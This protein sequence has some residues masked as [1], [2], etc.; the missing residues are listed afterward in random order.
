LDEK[1]SQRNRQEA[2]NSMG[3]NERQARQHDNNDDSDEAPSDV[4]DESA[5]HFSK[6]EKR[7]GKKKL[8]KLQAKAEA[9]AQRQQEMVEREERKKVEEQ[10]AKEDDQK[11]LLQEE[12]ERKLKEKRQLEKAERE[13]SELETYNKLK[14]SFNV[15]EHGFENDD[16][17]EDEAGQNRKFL[18][19]IKT[20]KVVH[21]SELASKSKSEDIIQRLKLCIEQKKYRAF[22]MIEENS[23]IFHRMNFSLWRNLLVNAVVCRLRIL[24]N[25]ATN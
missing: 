22:L 8:A 16:D 20:A 6:P 25:I 5:E 24:L 1:K 15:E 2:L 3:M 10:R 12:E 17:E 7:V 23:Y 13:R 4:D 19:H 21:I 18:N 14:E 11:K 9:K